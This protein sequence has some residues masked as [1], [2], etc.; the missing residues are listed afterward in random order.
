VRLGQSRSNHPPEA[1]SCNTLGSLVKYTRKD[2]NSGGD[3]RK[4]LID[5]RKKRI[6]EEDKEPASC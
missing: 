1:Q 5:E 4:A 3:T 6:T 2:K